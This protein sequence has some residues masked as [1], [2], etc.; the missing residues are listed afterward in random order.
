MKTWR[1]NWTNWLL[2]SSRGTWMI[3]SWILRSL[4]SLKKDTILI[5]TPLIEGSMRL[6]DCSTSFKLNLSRKLTLLM[7][8]CKTNSEVQY[9][10]KKRPT[11]HYQMMLKNFLIEK[12]TMMT[13]NKPW[14]RKQI[15]TIQRALF[16]KWS[17]FTNISNQFWSFWLNIW[18]IKLNQR[19]SQQT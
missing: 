8:R 9:L 5:R 3:S 13:L 18:R 17:N 19:V 14:K 4:L 11:D 15:F 16:T 1:L 10:T 6:I 12:L 2:V 7:L